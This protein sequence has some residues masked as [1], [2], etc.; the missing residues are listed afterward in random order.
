MDILAKITFTPFSKSEARL[1]SFILKNPKRLLDL[2][3]EEAA[4]I[5]GISSSSVYRFC[6]KLG[7]SGYGELLKEIAKSLAS[8]KEEDADIDLNFP[9]RED[10]DTMEVVE[11]IEADYL[12]TI[13]LQK[14]LMDPAA[15]DRAVALMKRSRVIDVYTSAGNLYIAENFCFQMK[16]IGAPVRMERDEYNLLLQA[17]GSDS[18]HAAVVITLGGRGMMV[19]KILKILSETKTPVI[20]IASPGFRPEVER[21][22][23][24]IYFSPAEHHSEKIS[25]FSTRFALMYILDTLYALYFK[26]DYQKSLERRREIYETMIKNT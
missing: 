11:E 22:A 20:L 16:E 26:A 13:K 10:E 7:V 15:L 24:R 25:S 2:T 3:V 17:G 21:L 19:G 1:A 8:R 14:A 18:S 23:S 4:E 12:K 9:F 6:D 5:S